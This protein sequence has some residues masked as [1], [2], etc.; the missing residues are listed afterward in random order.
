VQAAVLP[1]TDAISPNSSNV[2]IDQ[3]TVSMIDTGLRFELM[4]TG[5][6]SKFG[7]LRSAMR[8]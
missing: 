7:I 1:S 8:G 3:E 5:L 6:N 4:V 2:N